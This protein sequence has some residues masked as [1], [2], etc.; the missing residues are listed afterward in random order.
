MKANPDKCHLLLSN[1]RNCEANINENRIP[2]T[3]FAK[4]LGVT[5]DNRLSFNYPISSICKT[6]GNKFHTLA[7]VSNYMDRDKKRILFNSYFLSPFNYCP[8]IWTNHN[9][10][11]NNRVN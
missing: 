3:K 2:N 10:S 6:A 5:F 9:K 4:L 11:T 1:N 8:L 7:R